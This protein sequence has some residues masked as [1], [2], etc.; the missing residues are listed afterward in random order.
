MR[1]ASSI[2]HQFVQTWL[3]RMW[4]LS[5]ELGGWSGI[6]AGSG[7]T[8]L[9]PVRRNTRIRARRGLSINSAAGTAA[10]SR[11]QGNKFAYLRPLCG[12]GLAAHRW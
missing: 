8:D 12:L 2:A 3:C 11:R 4:R 9:K 6:R 1:Y 10:G 7:R 5:V